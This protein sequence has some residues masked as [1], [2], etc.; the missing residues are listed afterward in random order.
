MEKKVH[1]FEFLAKG[2]PYS[3]IIEANGFLFCSGVTAVDREKGLVIRDDVR[4]GTEIVL[5]NIQRALN[6]LGSGLEKVVKATVFLKDM[7]DFQ[8]MNEV[9]KTFFP[10]DPPVR[11]CIAVKDIPGDSP[12][13]IEVIAVK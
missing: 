2:G 12:L 5:A 8:A 13:E 4:K 11:T 6:A 3:H 1:D 9:Y 10:A 7:K